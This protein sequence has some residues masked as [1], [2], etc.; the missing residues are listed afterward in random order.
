MSAAQVEPI[1]YGIT[2]T[3]SYR[4]SPVA[5]LRAGAEQVRKRLEEPSSDED[6]PLYA[7]M[8][9]EGLTDYVAWPLHYTLGKSHMVSFAT[10]RPGGFT[11]GEVALL[12][13][14][15]P[16]LSLVTEVRFKNRFAR[17]LLETYVGPHASEQI[18]SGL[19]TRGSGVTITAAVMICDL[20]GFTAI[21]EHWPRDDVIALLN[22][23]FETLAIPIERHGGEILKF[24]GDGL[25]AVFRQ[26]RPTACGDALNAATDAR[27][28]MAALNERRN[29]RGSEPLGYGIGINVGDVMYGNIGTMSRLDFTV[30]GPAVN[31][32]ARLEALTK[33]LGRTALF[34]GAFAKKVND[35]SLQ[36]LGTYPLRGLGEPLEVFGF[37]DE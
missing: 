8:R 19:T 18:L 3:D 26:D 33:K 37:T 30:I 31:A 12:A 32:A 36:R 21:S 1:E 4:N 35:R 25:L 34:S 22:E 2:E 10:A 6:Y 28:G 29:A 20:R 17:R 5:A 15:L 13:D 27:R 9:C 16:V 24:I 23:Y 7:E 11:E 14:L